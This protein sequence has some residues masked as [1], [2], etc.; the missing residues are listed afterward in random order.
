MHNIHSGS[1]VAMKE[2]S[3]RAASEVNDCRPSL[4]WCCRKCV[5]L[6]DWKEE[7]K[8][9]KKEKKKKKGKKNG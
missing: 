3:L 4:L 7:I 1:K 6:Y 2:R 9:R 5:Y 8:S